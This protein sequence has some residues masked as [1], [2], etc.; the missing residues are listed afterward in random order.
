MT[1]IWVTYA[2]FYNNPSFYCLSAS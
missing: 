1:S 2:K